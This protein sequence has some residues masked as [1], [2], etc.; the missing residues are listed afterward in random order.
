M[1]IK[2]KTIAESSTKWDENAAR[3]AELFAREAEKAGDLWATNTQAAKDNF[4]SAITAVGISDRFAAGVRR[5]GAAKFA[6]KIRDVAADRFGPGIH[7]AVV[8]YNAGVEP[9]FATIAALTLPARK[10]RGDI[11]NLERVKTITT[12]LNA[13]RL[14]LLG[15]TRAPGA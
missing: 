12:A 10:P 5:A 13:K 7:A 14:A 11:S 6:R 3:A 9:Y 15:V 2:I 1:A 8:D 4:K